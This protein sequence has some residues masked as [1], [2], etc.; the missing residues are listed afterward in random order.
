MK[1][2]TKNFLYGVIGG[3]G[4]LTIVVTLIAVKF[5]ED[6]EEH[7][8]RAMCAR[9]SLQRMSSY[10]SRRGSMHSAMAF[11][12]TASLSSQDLATS[13]SRTPYAHRQSQATLLDSSYDICY[14]GM[15]KQFLQL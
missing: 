10:P 15:A 7:R 11:V 6:S 9:A 14:S 4:L 3:A 8:M 5:Q 12:N 1:R 2:S 13:S